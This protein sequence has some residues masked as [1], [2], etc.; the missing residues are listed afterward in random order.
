MNLGQLVINKA[1]CMSVC[2]WGRCNGVLQES[3][4]IWNSRNGL[5]LITGGIRLPFPFTVYIP[6]RV[7][8]LSFLVSVYTYESIH[9]SH[10][11]ML[12]M[13]IYM[14]IYTNM[15]VHVYPES[16]E[17]SIICVKWTYEWIHVLLEVLNT[18]WWLS[19]MFMQIYVHDLVLT[20]YRALFWCT[21]QAWSHLI[22]TITPAG[23]C[24]CFTPS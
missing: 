18:F 3:Y 2:V 15:H 13:C 17:C 21:P 23:T 6:S 5:C 20:I 16:G 10:T 19:D 4:K 22:L 9:I 7:K 12:Y 8:L 14:C 1:P 24:Y 11:Y